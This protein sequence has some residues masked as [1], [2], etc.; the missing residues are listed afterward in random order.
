[1]QS[2]KIIPKAFGD[3]HQVK[4][5]AIIMY[6]IAYCNYASYSVSKINFSRV[7]RAV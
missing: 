1:M 2:V 3:S 6:E 5:S 4:L 7:L